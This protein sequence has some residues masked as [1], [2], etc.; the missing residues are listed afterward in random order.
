[1]DEQGETAL[2]YLGGEFS[3]AIR[4]G[5]LLRAGAALVEGLFAPEQITARQAPPDELALAQDAYD[6]I[7]SSRPVYARIDV[8]RNAEDKPLVL[9]LE[10]TEPSMFFQHAPGSAGRFARAV[11]GCLRE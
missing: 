11:L 7:G 3:H 5:P 10:L 9:E 6:A 1:V 8:I 2:I 4:K